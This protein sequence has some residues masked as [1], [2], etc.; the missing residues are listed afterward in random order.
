MKRNLLAAFKFSLL[1]GTALNV[2]KQYRPIISFDL[3]NIF[4][5]KPALNYLVPFSVSLYPSTSIT[6]AGNSV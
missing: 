2:I 5:G 6:N 4:Y 1:V 3:V